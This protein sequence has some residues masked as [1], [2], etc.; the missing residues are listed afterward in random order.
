MQGAEGAAV[1]SDAHRVSRLRSV[2][3]VPAYVDD[4]TEA[5]LLAAATG[6]AARW[7]HV[8]GRRLQALG[9][10]CVRACARVRVRTRGACSLRTPAAR[11][12]GTVH[13]RAGLLPAPLPKWLLPLLQRLQADAGALFAGA[14][15]NHVLV[16][17][18]ASSPSAQHHAARSCDAVARRPRVAAIRVCAPRAAARAAAHA[19][20]PAPQVNAYAPGEGILP[21]QDGPL[22]HPAVA[23]VS[24]GAD[25]V[26]HFTPHAALLDAAAA[27]AQP[28]PEAA[29]VRLPRR[30]LLL[31][32]E[33]AYAAYLHGI[34]AQAADDLRGVCNA[35]VDAADGL[36]VAEAPRGGLRVSLTCRSVMKVRRN[37][38][39]TR[40]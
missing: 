12:G 33:E 14:Q 9:A 13:E 24:L 29:H 22:Y 35:G 19:P 17:Q 25:T 32:A 37:L 28:L 20:A 38:L 23:I 15:L 7:T 11:S 34:P 36:E 21:H 31:F 2:W 30:S 4:E 5:A 3:V 16:R 27:A 10:C 18:H 39:P 6:P 8:S 26:M 1:C 40:P